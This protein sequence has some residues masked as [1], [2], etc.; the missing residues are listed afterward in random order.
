MDR[1]TPA[2]GDLYQDVILKH[3][4][5]PS[6]RGEL[7]DA[8]AVV[9]MNNPSCGDQIVLHLRVRGGRVD[10]VRF[11]GY[12]CAISQAAASMMAQR[13]EGRTLE[14]AARLAARYREMLHGDPE[15]ARDRE[16]GDLRAL[17][18]VAKFPQRVR[19]AMLAWNALEEAE[20]RAGAD[21]GPPPGT[22]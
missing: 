8:D 18:G 2:L 12:G 21:P 3:Y 4:R 13:V 6:H 22:L 10:A 17:S 9:P 5:Q 20:R 14:E 7:E 16:L 19:C 11:T 15:A 1:S